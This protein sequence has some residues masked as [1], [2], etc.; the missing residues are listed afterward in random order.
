M[1]FRSAAP[2]S[3]A[4][5]AMEARWAGETHRI[6]LNG[7]ECSG[8]LE[9]QGPSFRARIEPSSFRVE[10]IETFATATRSDPASLEP[11]ATMFVLLQGLRNSMPHLPVAG[12]LP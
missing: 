3:A 11:C 9:Y 12:S 5:W 1:A 7:K 10:R 8:S 4:D 2:E 6:E